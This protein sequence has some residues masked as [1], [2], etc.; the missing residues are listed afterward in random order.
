MD[1]MPQSEPL[2]QEDEEKEVPGNYSKET[3]EYFIIREKEYLP[4]P[5]YLSTRQTAISW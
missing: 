4:D 5:H 3:L 1:I 2:E